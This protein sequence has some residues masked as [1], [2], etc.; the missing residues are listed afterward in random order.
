MVPQAACLALHLLCPQFPRSVRIRTIQTR[1][2]IAPGS[3]A[4]RKLFRVRMRVATFSPGEIVMRRG[5][6]CAR[7]NPPKADSASPMSLRSSRRITASARR[8]LIASSAAFKQTSSSAG[9]SSRLAALY[10]SRQLAWGIPFT[11]HPYVAPVGSDKFAPFKHASSVLYLLFKDLTDRYWG[12]AARLAVT[13]LS[14]PAL[15]LVLGD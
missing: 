4:N 1:A 10:Y 3:R 7:F 14:L 6:R 13:V 2:R 8:T 11:S 9:S 12:G 15:V 5:Y